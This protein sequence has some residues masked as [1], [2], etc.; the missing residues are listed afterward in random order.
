MTS[1]TEP[2]VKTGAALL[3]LALV[4]YPW[5]FYLLFDA[6][7]LWAVCV[8]FALLAVG[9]VLT[10]SGLA[11]PWRAAAAAA[12]LG[13]AFLVAYRQSSTLLKLYP[14]AVNLGLMS[15]ALYTLWRPPSAIERLM[16]ALRQPVS[17]A[18]VGYTRTLT[19]LWCGFFAANTAAAAYTALVASTSVWALYNGVVS[20][21]V[22]GILFAAE[23]V[24]RGFY[25][26]R[27]YGDAGGSTQRS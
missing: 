21:V 17:A 3:A 23:L 5:M 2:L 10:W 18:G 9:R 1:R 15:Y 16:H 6:V 27:V 12:V 13:F 4:L 11:W 20:Y 26:R 22:A 24:F 19:A 25:K 8:L 7:G 14:V